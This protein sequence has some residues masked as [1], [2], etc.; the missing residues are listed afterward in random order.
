MSKMCDTSTFLVI[1][2]LEEQNKSE[3]KWMIY[4][5]YHHHLFSS[6]TYTHTYV[7]AFYLYSN[8]KA[9]VIFCCRRT[10]FVRSPNDIFYI[11]I[12]SYVDHIF[13]R[14]CIQCVERCFGNSYTCLLQSKHSIQR[15]QLKICEAR[16]RNR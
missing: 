13:V 6:Y 1:L 12:K 14:N 4:V 10:I 16:E 11:C 3:Y 15:L 2:V 5:H 8:Y 7:T 9:K